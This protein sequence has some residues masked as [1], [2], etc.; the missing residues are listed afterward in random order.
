VDQ[1]AEYTF[2]T[3]PLSLQGVGSSVGYNNIIDHQLVTNEL[4]AS[5]VFNSTRVV[6]PNITSYSATTSDHYPVVSRFDFG[7]VVN[8]G[9]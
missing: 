3:R 7:W 5:Y 9:P 6:V 2:L 8:P 4:A 1:P